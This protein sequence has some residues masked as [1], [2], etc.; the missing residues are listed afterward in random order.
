MYF[1]KESLQN[2]I[3][4]D[5]DR[6]NRNFEKIETD[7]T[8]MATNEITNGDFSNGTT[9]WTTQTGWSISGGVAIGNNAN[10]TYLIQNPVFSNIGNKHYVAL[11][12]SN[13][14]AGSIALLSSHFDRSV[15][16]SLNGRKSTIVT[17][18]ISQLY[19]YSVMFT[20][21]IDDVMVIDLTTTFG[22]GNEPTVEQMDEIMSKFENSWFDG[23]K[24]LFQ[25]KASLN[26]LMALDARTEFDVKN[27]VVNGDFSN[28][29]SGWT[30]AN[31]EY[32]S[33]DSTIFEASPQS[34]KITTVAKSAYLHRDIPS[35]VG[36]KIY[37][38][39]AH[40]FTTYTSGV[41]YLRVAKFGTY[42][43]IS[44]K[45]GVTSTLNSWLRTS[46]V[47]TL[48]SD[49][50]GFRLMIGSAGDSTYTA[51]LDDVVAI[52]LTKTFGAGKE[53]TLAEMDRLMARYPNSWFDGT[54]PIQTIETLYQEKA[55]K[56]QEAWI[57]PTLLN[58]WTEVSGYP[59]RYMKDEMGFV[60]LKG[61]FTGAT[62]NVTCFILPVGYRPLDD[63]VHF[64]V[65]ANSAF[66]SFWIGSNGVATYNA[67]SPFA[68]S[69]N[70]ITFKGER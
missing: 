19:I 68:V 64:A 60:H 50:P 3:G 43:M 40:R 17:P 33:L 8:M 29:T 63:H 32:V 25:A 9:G 70:G 52:N 39:M 42:T 47:V 55:N 26:K 49:S 34:V 61:R 22:K 35:N 24:N 36:D 7:T 51:N 6:R 41:M 12:I 44:D 45:Y 27:E 48:P 23:T 56:V 4:E 11:K 37:V 62:I 38:S 10:S 31:A 1:E 67:G 65:N 2:N 66:G 28:G 15:G 18:K 58:G 46:N 20:G 5:L 16:Y 14:V 13:Y 54:K 59:I 21:N 30:V 69:L 57:T 53:P